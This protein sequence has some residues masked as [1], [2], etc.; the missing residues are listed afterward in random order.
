MIKFNC[1]VVI[2]VIDAYA[3][4]LSNEQDSRPDEMQGDCTQAT[5]NTAYVFTC[6][7]LVR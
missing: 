3:E 7:F 6:S 1:H 5:N 4:V 2:Q